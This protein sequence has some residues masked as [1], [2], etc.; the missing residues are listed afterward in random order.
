MQ[1]RH[2]RHQRADRLGYRRGKSLRDQLRLLRARRA[3]HRQRQSQYQRQRLLRRAHRGSQFIR[4][5]VAHLRGG[6]E[7]GVVGLTNLRSHRGSGD[8]H[9]C[10]GARQTSARQ[11]RG[12]GNRRRS[13]RHHRRARHRRH[14]DFA[15]HQAGGAGARIVTVRAAHQTLPAL[16]DQ[17]ELGHVEA[18]LQRTDALLQRRMGREQRAPGM[19]LAEQHVRDL[20][21]MHLGQLRAGL[22][23]AD[24]FQRPGD[25]I[26][27]TRELHRR[28]ISQRL[29]RACHRGLDQAREKHADAADHQQSQPDRPQRIAVVAATAATTNADGAAR[30]ERGIEQLASDHAEHDDT[31]HHAHQADVEAHVTVEH[32][33]VFVRDHAL[34]FVA[35][36]CFQAALGDADG[37]IARAVTGGE[38]IDAGLLFEHVN[39]RH[40]HAR[41]DGDFLDHVAQ[42]TPRRVAGVRRHR[43]G[44]QTARHRAAAAAQ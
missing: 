13:A 5:R 37:G 18:R 9:A 11:N 4:H 33:A 7:I 38:R 41:G 24:L 12:C 26:G 42:A 14:Q 20:F 34:Q 19:A 43:C 29:A 15:R 10:V 28:G 39:L 44:V 22:Q 3:F 35:V 16:G 23:G 17:L 8:W 36:E 2:R 27:L 32:V 25:A 30:P 31:E 21:A 1:L 40:R 6:G